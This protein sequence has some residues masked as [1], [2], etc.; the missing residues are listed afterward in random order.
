MHT[1]PLLF[2]RQKSRPTNGSACGAARVCLTSLASFNQMRMHTSETVRHQSPT[3]PGFASTYSRA[4]K[5]CAFACSQPVIAA[6]TVALVAIG[7]RRT[8]AL[9]PVKLAINAVI[10]L[11]VFLLIELLPFQ[12][13]EPLARGCYI[14]LLLYTQMGVMS[15]LRIAGRDL[16]L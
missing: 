12:L 5:Y 11:M 16:W 6:S 3:R 8:S 10:I 15:S 9:N 7:T 4:A 2:D 1:G 13:K 14:L